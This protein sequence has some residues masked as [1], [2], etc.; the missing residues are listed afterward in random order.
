[1]RALFVNENLGGHAALHLHLRHA[2]AAHP[3][4][5]ATFF[6]VPHPGL[7]RKLA[8]AP[9]PGLARLDGDLQPLRYQLAQ[10]LAARRRLAG[11]WRE[12]D[13]VHAYTQNA[14]LLSAAALRDR[15]SV[16]ATDTT[17]LVN[18]FELPYR[19]PGPL[20]PA[21]VRLSMRFERRVFGA[22][23]LVVAQSAWTA[24]Q[25]DAYGVDPARVRVVPFGV[26]VPPCPAPAGRPGPP[27]VT[28]V[29]ATMARKGGCQL[30]RVFG[31]DL[32]HRCRLTLVTREPVDPRPGV[33]VVG[34]AVPGD[35]RVGRVL[36]ETAVFVLPTEIDKTPYSVLEAMAAGV[37]VVATRVGAIPEMVADGE[38][39][40]LVGVR[41]DRALAGAIRT[42]LDDE[43]LRRRMGAAA[44]RRVLDRFDARRTTAALVAVLEEARRLHRRA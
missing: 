1:M 11:R 30:L 25:L 3:E 9:V 42:L 31:Q 20:T 17:T 22:A 37:P 27:R 14:M 39:G 38:A 29:G 8:A 5:D 23:T 36:A 40:L 15:P 43:H 21:T 12:F 41:D 4:V 19:G 44:R 2:L 7:A 18:G 32:A 13:V 10:S 34:D 35:G 16:V 24:G 33:E 26:A 6:D 28:F